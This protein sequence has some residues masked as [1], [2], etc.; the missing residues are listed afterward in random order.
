MAVTL[1]LDKLKT[2]NGRKGPLLLIIMDGIG[3]GRRDETDPVYLANT[4]TLDHLFNSRLCT[5][6]QAHGLAVGLPSDKDMGNS[7]VG[8]N[9]LGA[10]RVFDQGALLVNNAIKSG[11]IFKSDLWRQ[12]IDRGVEGGTVHFI[13]LLSD[14]NVH[15]HIDQLFSMVDACAEAAVTTLRVHALLDGRDVG[16]KSAL[17]YIVPTQEKL[18]TISREKGVDYCIASGGGRMKV[19][20]D[21]YNADWNIVKKGWEAHVL[22]KGRS[23]PSAEEAIRTFYEE[24]ERMTDQYMD[25]FVVVDDGGRPLGPIVDGDAVIFFNFR[26]DRAIEISRAF[27]EKDFHGFERGPLPEIIYAGMMEYDG[28]THIPPNFLVSP[29]DIDRTVSEYLCAEGIRMFAIS[30]TQKYGH[31]TYFWNGNRSGYI[32]ASLERYVE[33]PSDRIEFDRAPKMKAIEIKEQ[34]IEMMKTGDYRFGRVNFANGDMVGHTGVL[35]ATVIAVETVDQCVGEL[36]SVIDDLGGIAVITADHGNADEI[37]ARDEK[38]NK[39]IKTAH[40]LNPVPFIIHDPGY[41]GEYEMV[42]MGDQGLSN[43]AATLLNLLGY[44]KV[45][46]YDPSLI[47]FKR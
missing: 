33:I 29:P 10:G 6:L 8:H 22:G 42:E 27:M 9:A 45:K 19:T 47:H 17:D 15:S 12:I 41:Q 1:E 38:G 21:R 43:V 34:T 7:E 23:F 40:T 18:K 5:R 30:E 35:E 31:V 16:A 14:G 25:P 20:M 36:L 26:G 3:I 24:D 4:P 39:K 44:E 32:D 37:F 13:G 2:F 11:K 46:D 28:D